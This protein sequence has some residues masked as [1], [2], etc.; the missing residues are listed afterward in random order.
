MNPSAQ[1]E[2]VLVTQSRLT[3]YNPMDCSPP[4]SSIHGI[5]QTKILEWETILF[6]R[7]SSRPRDRTWVACIA[8]K[9]F[10]V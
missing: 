2:K 5:L 8:G 3:P 4:G 6:S 10:S 9:F 7:G 1:V